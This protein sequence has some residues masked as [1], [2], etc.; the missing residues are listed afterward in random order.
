MDV[1][2]KYPYCNNKFVIN[3][4][5]FIIKKRKVCIR[6]YAKHDLKYERI[7][8]CEKYSGHV[9]FMILGEKEE[10]TERQRERQTA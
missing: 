5:L 7:L 8:K 6:K 4:V 9:Q 10:E 3:V 1:N 2:F